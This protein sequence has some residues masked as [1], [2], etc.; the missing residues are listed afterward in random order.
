MPNRKI[1]LH[2][3][4]GTAGGSGKRFPSRRANSG[5]NRVHLQ[6]T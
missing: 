5:G 6:D 2:V 1:I 3:S 4:Y